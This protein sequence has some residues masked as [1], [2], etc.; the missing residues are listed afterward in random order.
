MPCTV[1][2]P[3]NNAA[4]MSQLIRRSPSAQFLSAEWQAD[5]KKI[6]NC[7]DCGHC[8]SR[9][10]YHLDTPALLRKCYED[11]KG[12]LSGSVSVG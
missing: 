12:I 4:R 7:A 2:I 9:C 11:Y 8:V 1:G 6:E 5:M 10:P 3:I